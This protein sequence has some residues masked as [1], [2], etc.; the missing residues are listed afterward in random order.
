MPKL[1]KTILFATLV[2]SGALAVVASPVFAQV[3]LSCKPIEGSTSLI[4]TPVNQSSTTGQTQ[5]NPTT[6]PPLTTTPIKLPTPTP[7]V[8]TFECISMESG[9]ATIARRGERQTPPLI[10]WNSFE[11]GSQYTPKV[12]CGI[13]S[14]RLTKVVATNGGKLKNLNLTYGRLNGESVICHVSDRN[15][16]CNSSNLLFT[17]RP[18]DR[19]RE[20]EILQKLINFSVLG[21][22]SAVQQSAALGYA[23]IGEEIEKFLDAKPT[24]SSTVKPSVMPSVKPEPIKPSQDTSI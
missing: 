2:T 14:D 5:K 10:T 4:C 21:S 17:L 3:Q 8:T 15:Q 9:Y 20:R 7:E 16:L 6:P 23:P 22:G 1:T 12:R 18:S 11:L 24:E 13:V 19:G